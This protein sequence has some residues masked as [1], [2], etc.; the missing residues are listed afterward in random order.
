MGIFDFFKGKKK[1]I[2]EEKTE[3][4][5]TPFSQ[6]KE[7]IDGTILEKQSIEKQSRIFI[8]ELGLEQISLSDFL[9]LYDENEIT[10]IEDELFNDGSFSDEYFDFNKDQDSERIECTL[11]Q[12][13]FEIID[14]I[15]QM[16]ICKYDPFVMI[17]KDAWYGVNNEGEEVGYISFEAFYD[18]HPPTL[19]GGEYDKKY[20]MNEVELADFK[21]LSANDSIM[22][23][24]KYQDFYFV[25]KSEYNMKKWTQKWLEQDYGHNKVVKEEKKGSKKTIKKK[26]TDPPHWF[27]GEIYEEGDFVKNLGTGKGVQ[28]NNIESSLWDTCSGFA[29]TIKLTKSADAEEKIIDISQ[30]FKQNNPE[31]HKILFLDNLFFEETLPIYMLFKIR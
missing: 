3:E 27:D 24:V 16:K 31:A 9:G 30:W 14:A 22:Y 28:L 2:K 4:L 15:N 20:F 18:D 29:L 21:E 13:S 26:I 12:G 17:V 7:K 8:E 23:D 19:R 5:K 6:K 1:V 25:R 11:K 10:E